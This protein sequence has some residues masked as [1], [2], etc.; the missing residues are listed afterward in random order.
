[1]PFVDVD[2]A[3]YFLSVFCM[4]VDFERC[5]AQHQQLLRPCS[6]QPHQICKHSCQEDLYIHRDFFHSAIHCIYIKNLLIPLFGMLRTVSA[7]RSPGSF[8]I[9]L[10]SAIALYRSVMYLGGFF[11]FAFDRESST[12]SGAY[13]E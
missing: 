6:M 8:V 9:P 2:G 4:T 3:H 1:M 10:S 11:G 7:S 13:G 5:E 12:C